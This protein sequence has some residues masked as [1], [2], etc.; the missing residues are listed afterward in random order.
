MVLVFQCLIKKETRTFFDHILNYIYIYIYMCVHTL[1][2][3]IPI[4]I[5][6]AL[7]C[8]CTAHARLCVQVRFP[9]LAS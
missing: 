4:N 8:F 5:H 2:L 3:R 7:N 6:A 9:V 1:P